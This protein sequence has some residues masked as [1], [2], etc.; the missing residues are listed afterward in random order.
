MMAQARMVLTDGTE[1]LQTWVRLAGT[2]VWMLIASEP[3][4][5]A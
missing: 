2:G 5:A 3:L 1:H 4:E